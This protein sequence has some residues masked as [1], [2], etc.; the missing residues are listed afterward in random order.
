MQTWFKDDSLLEERHCHPFYHQSFISSGDLKMLCFAA[1]MGG[2][3]ESFV[4]C[5]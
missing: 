4:G 1:L 2:M 3:S 5:P